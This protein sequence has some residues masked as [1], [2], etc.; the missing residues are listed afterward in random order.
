MEF[1][2]FRQEISNNFKSKT[3]SKYVQNL[4][5]SCFCVNIKNKIKSYYVRKSIN[6]VFSRSYFTIPY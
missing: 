1:I 4:N 5:V 3:L 6:L 2:A